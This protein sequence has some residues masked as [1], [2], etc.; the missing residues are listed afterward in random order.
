M[1]SI[2]N[3]KFVLNKVLETQIHYG[4]NINQYLSIVE[5]D[6]YNLIV[7]PNIEILFKLAVGKELCNFHNTMHGGAICTLIDTTTTLAISGMDR[8]L[9]H[10]V[11]VELSSYFLN[12]IKMNS[13][14]LI[15]CKIPKIG[16]TLA[17]SNVDIYDEESLKLCANGS[18]VKAMLEK[19]WRE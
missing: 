10:N 9:R 11:S 17:Y 19:T 16:K 6:T 15:H 4:K 14:I 2:P 13:N 12:P 7:N 1:N 8:E 5:K 18:H 3:I